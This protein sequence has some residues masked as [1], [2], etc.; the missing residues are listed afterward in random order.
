MN[1]LIQYCSGNAKKL[2]AD[3]VIN[4]DLEKGYQKALELLYQ[5]FGKPYDV[6]KSYLETLTNTSAIKADGKSLSE[7]AN[8]MTR[9]EITLSQLGYTGEIN[10][11]GTL[12]TIVNRLPFH[13]KKK[14]TDIATDIINRTGAEVT[15]KDL[16]EFVQESAEAANNTWGESLNSARS[17]KPR[18]K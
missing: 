10:N 3:C 11:I 12:R 15:F 7:F 4:P 17:T 13:L 1:Y 9:C 2:I 8:E 14:W 18:N 16:V 5:Q 6:A